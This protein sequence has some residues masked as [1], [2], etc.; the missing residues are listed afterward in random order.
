MIKN[1]IFDLDGTLVDSITDIYNC[2]NS[3]LKHFN[4]KSISIED[5][6]QFVGNGA[7]ILIKK[8]VNKYSNNEEIEK[9]VYEYY[10]KYYEEHCVDSTQLYEGVYDSLELLYSNNINMFIISNK[11]NKM[12]IKTAEKLNIYKYFKALIG[13]GIYT[14]RKP[15]KNIWYS[16]K[17][18]YNLLEDETIMVGDGVPDYEFACNS[19]IKCILALYGITNKDILL[20]LKNNYYL[21]SFNEIADYITNKKF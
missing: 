11:P 15:D 2:V 17:K 18:D 4:L 12:V 16:L 7:A 13:D 19:G 10:I 9:E 6:H 3:T 5:A 20:D 8:A 21:N 1:I 14:Y